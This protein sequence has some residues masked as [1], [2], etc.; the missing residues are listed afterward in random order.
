VCLDKRIDLAGAGYAAATDDRVAQCVEACLACADR[1]DAAA[2]RLVELGERGG[3]D[4]LIAGTATARLVADLL[5]EDGEVEHG[6]LDLCIAALERCG[7]LA[8]DEVV[9]SCA[10]AVRYLRALG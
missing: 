5:R 1:C 4:A 6:L 8:V 9:E 3:V 10:E 7:E 2:G